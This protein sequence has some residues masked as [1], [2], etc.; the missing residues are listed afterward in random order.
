MSRILVLINRFIEKGLT[1]CES[2]EEDSQMPSIPYNKEPLGPTTGGLEPANSGRPYHRQPKP[3][4]KPQITGKSFTTI[5]I[6][7]SETVERTA[8]ANHCR[9]EEA[10]PLGTPLIHNARQLRRSA[11]GVFE[12]DK[13]ADLKPRESEI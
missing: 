10:Y 7:A 6:S 5:R 1:S 2:T 8:P 11:K 9:D 3:H 4:K 12:R 13:A